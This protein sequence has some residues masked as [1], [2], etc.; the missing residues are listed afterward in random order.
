MQ[1]LSSPIGIKPMPLALEVRTNHW[2]ARE[3]P[4]LDCFYSCSFVL[5]LLMV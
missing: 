3:V 2:P 1:N 5:V 4:K